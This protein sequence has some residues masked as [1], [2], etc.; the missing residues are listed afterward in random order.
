MTRSW[1]E[2]HGMDL[3]PSL[4]R[5]RPYAGGWVLRSTGSTAP[6]V[7]LAACLMQGLLLPKRTPYS[8]QANFPS[9]CPDYSVVYMD[10]IL[11]TTYKVLSQGLRP[12]CVS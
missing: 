4:L 10:P 9:P 6:S 5:P 11:S 7:E 3:I 8:F 1:D 2:G 12:E